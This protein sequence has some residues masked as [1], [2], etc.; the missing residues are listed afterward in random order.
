MILQ[1][2]L[3]FTGE[4]SLKR[5]EQFFDDDHQ[6][7]VVLVCLRGA[8]PI[9]WDDVGVST[10]YHPFFAKYLSIVCDDPFTLFK[11]TRPVKLRAE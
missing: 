3:L 8:G 7:K 6:G 9:D 11:E 10:C 2:F 1:G 4:P 5:L